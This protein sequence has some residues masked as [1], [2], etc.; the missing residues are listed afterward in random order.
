MQ[1]VT[2][3]KVFTQG[4][5]GLVCPVCGKATCTHSETMGCD[6]L[7]QLGVEAVPVFQV[8]QRWGNA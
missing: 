1:Q 5:A 6:C 7:L 8:Q 4:T 2:P 3:A